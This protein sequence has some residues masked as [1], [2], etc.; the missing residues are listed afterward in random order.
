MDLDKLHFYDG[1]F[2]EIF[3]DP[4]FKEIRKIIT[5]QI[6]DG[7]RVIDIGCGTGALVFDL[8]EKCAHATGIEL[9]SKMFSHANKLKKIYGIK[10]VDFKHRNA[11]SLYEI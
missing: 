9:S 3:I 6:R 1:K 4:V 10:N 5:E 11:A 2:Y 8:S 7:S